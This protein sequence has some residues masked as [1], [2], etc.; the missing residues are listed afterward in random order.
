MTSGRET[1]DQQRK[2]YA[3][4]AEGLRAALT[5]LIVAWEALP[6]ERRYSPAAVTAWLVQDMKPAIDAARAIVKGKG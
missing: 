5:A 4:E 2:G 1:P 3:E 6:G